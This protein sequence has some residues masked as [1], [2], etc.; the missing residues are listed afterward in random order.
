LSFGPRRN[1]LLL[2]LLPAY[3]DRKRER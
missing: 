1:L 2:S 3:C